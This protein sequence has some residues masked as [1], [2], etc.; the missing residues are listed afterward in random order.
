MAG[1]V[2]GN[3][4]CMEWHALCELDRYRVSALP[5]ETRSKIVANRVSPRRM[6]DTV[7]I[8]WIESEGRGQAP[9]TQSLPFTRILL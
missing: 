7:M 8:E 3:E 6:S 9:M 4:T 1:D 5:T 2:A